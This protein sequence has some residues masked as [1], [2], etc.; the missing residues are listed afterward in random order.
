MHEER[1]K[2]LLEWEAQNPGDAFLKF[3]LAQ[4]YASG[5]MDEK[6]LKYYEILVKEF[7]GYLPTYYQFGNLLERQNENVKAIEVYKLGVTVA[8][9]T[10]DSKTLRELQEA[11]NML[12]DE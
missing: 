2:K 10:N 7:P 12:Q 8:R 3:A 9:Q 5:N 1:L 6:A 4:E 11:I